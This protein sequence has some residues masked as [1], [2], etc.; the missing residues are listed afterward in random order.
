MDSTF[1]KTEGNRKKLVD[2]ERYCYYKQ[3]RNANKTKIYWRCLLYKSNCH[4][5]VHTSYNLD[6]IVI[7]YHS[8]VNN[9]FSSFSKVD[10]QLQ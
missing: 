7:L 2:D 9:H 5:R 6:T 10:A 3:S 4:V 8:G 1:V